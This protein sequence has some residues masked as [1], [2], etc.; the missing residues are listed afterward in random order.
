MRTIRATVFTLLL[1]TVAAGTT[2]AQRRLLD[3]FS[4][5][6]PMSRLCRVLLIALVALGVAAPSAGAAPTKRLGDTLGAMW[7]KVLETP[8]A[9]ST[10]PCIDLGGVV[11]PL[12]LSGGNIK[13]NVRAGTE[14]FVAAWSVECST[15]EVGTVFFGSNPGELRNCAQGLNEGVQVQA[16]LDG[17]P[18]ALTQ[19]TSGV[20]Q[21]ALPKDNI[22][23]VDGPQTG[24]SVADGFV[25]FV[26][27]L[28]TG[29]YEIT[30]TTTFPDGGVI[31]N[32]TT[33]IVTGR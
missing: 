26:G 4:R 25:A 23:G 6:G 32:T 12:S 29:K 14:I 22:L 31:A 5:G 11:A 33:I 18:V 7:E 2:S 30:I 10:L 9:Q 27:P 24:L 21:I 1:T 28:A 17:A 20:L 16:A 3:P 8:N 13:C 15:F 19:V